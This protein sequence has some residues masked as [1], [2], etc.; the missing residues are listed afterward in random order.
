M[1]GLINSAGMSDLARLQA[2]DRAARQPIGLFLPIQRGEDPQPYRALRSA[3]QQVS[4]PETPAERKPPDGEE[5]D[6]YAR[7]EAEARDPTAGT[8]TMTMAET[9]LVADGATLADPRA[10]DT[11]VSPAEAPAATTGVGQYVDVTA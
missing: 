10:P 7:V 4:L 11:P 1:I 9:G 2:T 3:I 5:S 8:G 6:R